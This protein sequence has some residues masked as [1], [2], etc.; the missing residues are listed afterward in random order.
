ML[1]NELNENIK[2]QCYQLTGACKERIKRKIGFPLTSTMNNNEWKC[3]KM[4]KKPEWK[5]K[6][7]R[8]NSIGDIT[9]AINQPG[10]IFKFQFNFLKF[11]KKIKNY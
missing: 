6:K 3:V 5:E 10:M 1:C 9:S 7:N 8:I 2:A 4:T 11:V